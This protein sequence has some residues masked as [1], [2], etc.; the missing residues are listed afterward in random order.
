MNLYVNYVVFVMDYVN[1]VWCWLFVDLYDDL[2][3][4]L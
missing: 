3:Y 4:E 2:C 1:Y